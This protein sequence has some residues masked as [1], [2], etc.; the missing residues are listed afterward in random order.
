M[1]LM[2]SIDGRQSEREGE[3]KQ[4]GWGNRDKYESGRI[5]GFLLVL[6]VNHGQ[7]NKRNGV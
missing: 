5:Y 3:K 7:C 2:F 6:K 1:L 4:L